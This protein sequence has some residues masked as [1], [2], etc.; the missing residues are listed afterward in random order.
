MQFAAT[1]LR[2]YAAV[3][4]VEDQDV[5]NDAFEKFATRESLGRMLLGVVHH[6]VN[7]AGRD[8]L[9]KPEHLRSFLPA[10]SGNMLTAWHFFRDNGLEGALASLRE[11][12]GDVKDPKLLGS[13][14]VLRGNLRTVKQA[15]LLMAHVL[16][17]EEVGKFLVDGGPLGFRGAVEKTK[18]K[19]VRASLVVLE[20]LECKISVTATGHEPRVW[21]LL[22]LGG[23]YNYLKTLVT[24]LLQRT[25]GRSKELLKLGARSC[26]EDLDLTFDTNT[27]LD[28]SEAFQGCKAFEDMEAEA[29]RIAEADRSR[30][31]NVEAVWARARAKVRACEPLSDVS[32][33]FLKHSSQ[34]EGK[35]IKKCGKEAEESLDATYSTTNPGGVEMVDELPGFLFAKKASRVGARTGGNSKIIYRQWAKLTNFLPR[36]GERQGVVKNE[37]LCLYQNVRSLPST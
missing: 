30:A 5:D 9:R 12:G 6:P 4:S 27:D 10:L 11:S 15:A 13:L 16:G 24:Q 18:A 37:L 23:S 26:V 2:T 36:S 3:Q 33:L 29:L 7:K 34:F 20:R 25:V 8:E 21:E 1:A 14:K 22:R 17:D 32:S 31:A 28:I 35:D 19:V